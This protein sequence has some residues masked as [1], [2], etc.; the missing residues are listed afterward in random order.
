MLTSPFILFFFQL[1]Y[2][3]LLAKHCIVEKTM[4][5]ISMYL[6]HLFK[7]I[8]TTQHLLKNSFQIK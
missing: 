4:L 7:K 3:Y 2:I 8:K 6:F 5:L 1:F